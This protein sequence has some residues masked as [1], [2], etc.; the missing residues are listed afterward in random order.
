MK[1]SQELAKQ[2]EEAGFP[3]EYGMYTHGPIREPNL[4]ELIAACSE[5]SF[6]LTKQSEWHGGG[7]ITSAQTEEPKS[8]SLSEME[9]V[10]REAK[11]STPEE[12]VAKLW[13]ALN[14]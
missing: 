5:H 12:A 6:T 10:Y 1:F 14:N 4:S 9:R 7:W 13:L 11:G 8:L 3:I 2:L